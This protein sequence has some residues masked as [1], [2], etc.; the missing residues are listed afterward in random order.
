VLAFISFAER[1]NNVKAI[2]EQRERVSL[3][4]H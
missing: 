4:D 2:E 3:R 1:F